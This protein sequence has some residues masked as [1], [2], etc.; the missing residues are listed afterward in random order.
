MRIA[1][2]N[3]RFEDLSVSCG[4]ENSLA[5]G[6]SRP[7]M[8]CRRTPFLP[9]LRSLPDGDPVTARSAVLRFIEISILHARTVAGSPFGLL[10]T[11]AGGMRYSTGRHIRRPADAQS[12]GGDEK[13]MPNKALHATAAAPGSCLNDNVSF[14]LRPSASISG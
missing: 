10:K 8:K 1:R 4:F 11:S 5:R 14:Y 3:L 7:Q 6:L 9:R 12:V 13:E 2:R